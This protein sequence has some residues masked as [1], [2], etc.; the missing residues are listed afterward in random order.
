MLLTIIGIIGTLVPTILQNRGIIGANTDTLITSLL[1]PITALIAD[2]KAGNTKT[3]N[4]LAALGALSGV[5][6]VLKATTGLA[7]TVL[8]EINNVDLDVQAALT[9]YVTAGT[10]L[11]LTIY[12]PIAEV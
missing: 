5:I 11:D 3:Q 10:G 7:P 12:K 9:A 6:A 8:A 1:G 4:A 2:L